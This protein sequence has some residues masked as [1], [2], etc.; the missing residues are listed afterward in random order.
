[1]GNR[2]LDVLTVQEDFGCDFEVKR[3]S[4]HKQDRM[5]TSTER[6]GASI[7]DAGGWLSISHQKR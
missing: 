6:F 1:M 4:R 7:S 5:K 3:V 2:E